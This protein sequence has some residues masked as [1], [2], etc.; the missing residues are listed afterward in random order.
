MLLLVVA[1]SRHV[2]ACCCR[3][4]GRDLLVVLAL[5]QPVPHPGRPDL[6]RRRHGGAAG[7]VRGRML[8][9]AA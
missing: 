9:P 6:A 4:G 3:L 7:A 2:V 1:D 8:L 5:A